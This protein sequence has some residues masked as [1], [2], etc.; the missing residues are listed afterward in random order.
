MMI[1]FKINLLRYITLRRI[2]LLFILFTIVLVSC[3]I[4]RNVPEE[5][6]L[7]NKEIL[8]IDTKDIKAGDIEPFLRQK[9]NKRII[10]FRF[11]LRMY[12]TA[13]PYK[14]K[15]INKWLKT[16]GEEPIILDT[17]LTSQGKKNIN[18]YL[19]SKGYYHSKVND[20]TIYKGKKADVIYSIKLGAPYKIKDL[21][22]VV[23]DTSIYHLILKDSVNSLVNRRKKLDT[24]MLQEERSRIQAY[25]QNYG[26]YFFT[27]DYI[28]FTAD[29]SI[30]KHKVDLLLNIM[31]RFKTTESGE[32]VPQN[33]LKYRINKV[34]FYPN[35][36][37]R[38][39]IASQ[40]SNK[41]DTVLYNG[42]YFIFSGDPGIVLK[43]LDQSNQI[44][45]GTI[46]SDD[47][48]QRTQSNLNSLK[49]FRMVNIFFTEEVVDTTKKAKPDDIL[50]FDDSS[51]KDSI[52]VGL[53]NCYIQLSNHTLQSYQAEFVGTNTSGALG[54][55]GNLSYQHKNLFRGAEIF[56]VKLR[57]LIETVQKN[58]GIG[59][60]N[61][62]Y[63]VEMGGSVGLS[64]PK[65]LS[66]FASKEFIKKYSPRTQITASYNFQRRPDYTRTI[67][68][69]LFG[70]IWKNSK[71]LTHTV[72]PVEINA[73]NITNISPDFNAQ[74]IGKYLENSYKNQI[75]TLSS[76]SLTFNNQN[77]KKTTNYTYLR[78]NVESSGNI[79]A[80]IYSKYGT[81]SADSTYQIFKTS[82]SQYLRSDLNITYHQVIDNNNA[83]VYRF[84][85]GVGY[86]YG[87]SKALPFDKKY[88]SGGA[89][90][91]RAWSARSLGPGSVK[92]EN[93]GYFN[94][95]G[96]IKLEANVEYRYKIFWQLEG[97]LF[98]DAGN[99]W[100]FKDENDKAIFKPYNFYKQIALGTGTG[101]RANLGFLTVRIDFGLRLYDPAIPTDNPN[102]QKWVF[103]RKNRFSYD[104][105][106]FNFG[107]GY[108]F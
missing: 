71:Y 46:Y 87:N 72:N 31:N 53:L 67:A 4:T 83:F 5:K 29:T 57:G 84:F 6:Y 73:I 52:P 106:T 21:K 55:E 38:K 40:G 69:L 54:A 18:L 79:L 22:Y 15:G 11:H 94:Q 47:I 19:I 13:N 75:I 103:L 63:S 26:Y 107:I 30:G 81:K 20:T 102:I 61:F 49:L 1:S 9:P 56:D 24:D 64:L 65:F 28:T 76:Y 92:V 105:W 58:Q 62:R 78:F 93:S 27:K 32:K 14:Y 17:F 108:P 66:P 85:A 34:Y 41:I 50:F 101:F 88:F 48:V 59:N 36:D 7:L 16:I 89:N 35:F 97:A 104:D 12:N 95:T 3:N 74:I 43:V 10:G 2:P 77:L 23:E 42:M 37:P 8:K 96:D 86:P 51:K 80:T 44:R 33:F 91:I 99:I 45:P 90:G 25:L 70:Y 60:F 82:F 68:S 98:L 100:A 39:L